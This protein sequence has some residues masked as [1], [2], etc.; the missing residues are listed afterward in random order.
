M[1][2]FKYQP[3]IQLGKDTTEY[4]LI[5]KDFITT[6][7]IEDRTILKINSE[8][9][10]LL[11]EEALKDVSFFLRKSHLKKLALIL[12]DPESSDN[13]KFVANNLLKNAII[14][15]KGELPSCQDTGTAIVMGKK[16]ENVWTD[17]NDSESLSSGI[18]KTYQ[19]KNLRY[20]Q[21][22]PLSMMDEK[23]TGSNLPAQIDIYSTKG[24]EYHFLFLAKGGGS[25]NKTFLYQQTKSLLNEDSLEKFIKEKL[26]VL[27]TA[28]CPPY[29]LAVVIG[30]TSAEDN[31][32]T[33]KLASAGYF[34][35]LPTNGDVSG[36]A[37]RDL[38]WEQRGKRISCHNGY[39]C[40]IWR[41]VFFT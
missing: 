18:Y 16:G 10:A 38:E 29:H 41:K 26:P 11:A 21:M 34:D 14:A 37:F 9:L 27:G 6:Q 33:V 36:R 39:R 2:D 23:N 17:K 40:S 24:S 20:S 28:A 22:A 31:L 8:G 19:E 12:E 35:S 5:S 1:A 4:R 25:A 30:G 7:I 15:S 32:K 13:D 3:P